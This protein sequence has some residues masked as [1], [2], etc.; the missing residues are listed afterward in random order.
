[1]FRLSEHKYSYLLY[2]LDLKPERIHFPALIQLIPTLS[3]T[4]S[5]SQS[6]SSQ[7]LGHTCS[8]T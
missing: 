8:R 5:A 7:A 2:Y 4:G 1:M 3:T 6:Q